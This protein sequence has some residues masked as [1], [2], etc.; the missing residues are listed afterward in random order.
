MKEKIIEK[1][2]K[3][4]ELIL[5]KEDITQEETNFIFNFLCWIENKEEKE[6]LE[7]EREEDK[8]KMSEKMKQM[9]EGGF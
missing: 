9:F 2:S 6:K 4:A 7:K 1:L 3:K 5:E 8:R